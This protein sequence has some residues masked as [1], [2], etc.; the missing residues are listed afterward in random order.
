MVPVDQKDKLTN[1]NRLLSR[2]RLEKM[3]PEQSADR[4]VGKD[5]NPAVVEDGY[6]QSSRGIEINAIKERVN[7]LPEVDMQKV[8]RLKQQIAGGSYQ[9]SS[10]ILAENILA[11]SVDGN[12]DG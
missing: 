3:R 9:V 6:V 4:T 10:E 11:A 7:Q 12:G 2:Q 5:K 8:E 1:I